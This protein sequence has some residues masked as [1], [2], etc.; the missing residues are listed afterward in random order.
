MTDCSYSLGVIPQTIAQNS[1]MPV[2]DGKYVLN[3][4]VPCY[5]VYECRDGFISVGA[6]EPKFW[7]RFCLEV[8]DAKHLVSKGLL[9]G[10]AA[11]P[12]KEEVIPSMEEAGKSELIRS[13]DLDVEV[14][15]KGKKGK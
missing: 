13:R 9:M 5:N 12:V 7:R 1:S 11:E 8:L 10:E 4:S 14:E 3:G 15:I 6:L 2:S